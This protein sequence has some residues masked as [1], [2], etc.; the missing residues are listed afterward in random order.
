MT[1]PAGIEA[2]Y[3]EA[4]REL[5]RRRKWSTRT[6]ATE[7]GM[8]R[9]S[10]RNYEQGTIVP[11]PE[12][13]RK[14]ARALN[15]SPTHLARLAAALQRNLADLD[16]Q[17]S[18]GRER[19]VAEIAADLADD[20][21]RAT[22]PL[23]ERLVAEQASP[24]P[25]AVPE[26]EVRALAP[27][28]RRLGARGLQGLLD[29][30]PSFWSWALVKLVGEESE[31]VA[32]VDAGRALELARFALRIAERVTGGEGWISR[33]F[34]WAFLANARRVGGDLAGA[35]EASARSARLRAEPPEA[36]PEL[37]EPWRLLDLGASLRID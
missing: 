22:L 19:R 27:V 14:I 9:G 16:D 7:S 4:I 35:E 26:E 23:V 21:H 24:P 20:F 8:S 29:K 30:L 28:L 31:R 17:G 6:L 34:A 1:E 3:G 33:I 37:P 18:A 15:V 2:F 13:R 11:R 32:S 12:V 36:R 5:R 25:P 10:I